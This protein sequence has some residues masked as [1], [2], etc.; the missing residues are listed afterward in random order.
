MNISTL[1]TASASIPDIAYGIL[2][3]IREL[4]TLLPNTRILLVSVLPRNGV[5]N[6]NNIVTLNSLIEDYH[7]GQNV[8]YLDIF[9]DFTSDV[10]GSKFLFDLYYSTPNL[11]VQ[12]Q[13][14]KLCRQGFFDALN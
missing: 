4:H 13:R 12:T 3:I 7:D 6:F 14:K 5:A 1:F 8:F 9:D 2:T 10:W 11:Q